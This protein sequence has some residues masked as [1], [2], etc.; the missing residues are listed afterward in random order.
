MGQ[1]GGAALGGEAV[2][3]GEAAVVGAGGALG[4]LAATAGIAA[5]A[6][7][8]LGAAISA[9]KAQDLSKELDR[10]RKTLTDVGGGNADSQTLV[11]N[12]ASL[13]AE[14]ARLREGARGITGTIGDFLTGDKSGAQANQLTELAKFLTSQAA[15]QTERQSAASGLGDGTF[16]P[17]GPQSVQALDAKVK[18]L[19]ASGDSASQIV[20]I[21]NRAIGE[22]AVGAGAASQNVGKL[23]VGRGGGT[24]FAADIVDT[25]NNTVSERRPGQAVSRSGVRT[26]DQDVQTVITLPD[27]ERRDLQ[28]RIQGYLNSLNKGGPNAILDSSNLKHIADL[29]ANKIDKDFALTPAGRKDALDQFLALLNSRATGT[30]ET[31]TNSRSI[32]DAAFIA[33]IPQQ[34]QSV[35]NASA[36]GANNT[37]LLKL[38]QSNAAQLEAAGRAFQKTGNPIPAEDQQ[39]SA[40]A[41]K[42]AFDAFATR[43]Q[44]LQKVALTLAGNDNKQKAA[45]DRQTANILRVAE[46]VDP[47]L[48]PTA[49]TTLGGAQNQVT[50]AALATAVNV[51]NAAA[52]ALAAA[53]ADANALLAEATALEA[54]AA[55]ASSLIGREDGIRAAL[56]GGAGTDRSLAAQRLAQGAATAAQLRAPQVSDA[57][58]VPN[59]DQMAANGQN[60]AD[61]AAK[62]AAAASAKVDTPQ[63]IAAARA[64]A[65]AFPGAAVEQAAAAVGVAAATLSEQ[66]KRDVAYY[67]ALKALRQAQYAYQQTLLEAA[68]ISREVGED[69]TNPLTVA[70][71]N[72]RTAQAKANSDRAQG[73]PSEVRNSDLLAVRA[74]QN[75]LEQTK[76]QQGLDQVTTN[77]DL[78]RITQ[79]QY[80]SYLDSQRDHLQRIAKRTFQ[81][82]QELNQIDK[83]L[84]EAAN[85]LQ[86]QF[87]LGDIKLPTV[88]EVR[89]SIAGAGT[90]NNYQ[91]TVN[92]VQISGV[93][94]AKVVAYLQSALGS[95]ATSRYATST[96]KGS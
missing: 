84:K 19:T 35:S 26:P 64:A 13:G 65:D 75:A 83:L 81:Q 31:A 51:R 4:G 82:Q 20:G 87:N 12:A 52:A 79:A 38:Q 16:G 61:K 76:F 93:D 32:L 45:I 36:R 18:E 78:E 47:A 11:T 22:L 69:L 7:V 90:S 48:L 88:F 5:G 34:A 8:V 6:F 33:L 92:N 17:G 66:T 80:V 58:F 89:R 40:E 56:T 21:L 71:E 95:S 94:F 77:K 3:G 68:K 43:A 74:A 9:M 63:E 41:N 42:A 62:Q 67:N 49:F 29:Y 44:E 14:A 91:S 30:Q 50:N 73:A 37:E 57:S 15:A 55:A 28:E 96:R 60:Q 85:Q 2:V 27:S 72:L 54:E 53:R 59:I 24:G 70:R 10:A 25:L 86:G 23:T 39:K 46:G 1:I